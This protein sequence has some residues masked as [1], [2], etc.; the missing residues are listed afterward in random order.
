MTVR[1]KLF[2]NLQEL[3]GTREIQMD[4]DDVAF[5]LQKLTENYPALNEEIWKNKEKSMLVDRI[6][7]MVN[8]RNIDFLDGLA[9]RL[10]EGDRIAIFPLIAGG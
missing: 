5:L 4:A 7:I 6:K 1:V 9:T 8:G 3:A 10:R 2:A